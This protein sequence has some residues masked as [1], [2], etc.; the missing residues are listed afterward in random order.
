MDD[1]S[2]TCT[3][4]LLTSK[5]DCK[6]NRKPLLYRKQTP[7][8]TKAPTAIKG[9]LQKKNKNKN[10]FKGLLIFSSKTVVQVLSA[11]SMTNSPLE[12]PS[13]TRLCT[14]TEIEHFYSCCD[15]F[16]LNFI[17]TKAYSEQRIP[18]QELQSTELNQV[19]HL[20]KTVKH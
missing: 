16:L 3:D 1:R 12:H 18:P 19:S 4:G 10:I 15:S 14:M 9:P 5:S 13:T 8:Q 2:R 11:E 7:T 20:R 6:V 17:Q